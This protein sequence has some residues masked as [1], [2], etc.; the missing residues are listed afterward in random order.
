[1]A[2]APEDAYGP[3]DPEAEAEVP[4]DLIPPDAQTAGQRLV[5]RS[6][7]GATRVVR[8]KEV[9]A[10]TVLVDLNHPFAG[11]TLH[12]AIRVVAIEDPARP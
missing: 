9:R 10:A 12:F 8:I 5:A 3:I 4:R 11:M 6:P 2:V 7:D 1:V